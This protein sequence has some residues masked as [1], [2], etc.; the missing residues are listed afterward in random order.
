MRLEAFT[1]PGDS[2]PEFWTFRS[3]DGRAQRGLPQKDRISSER[4]DLR[5]GVVNG[6]MIFK[7]L[8]IP[9]NRPASRREKSIKEST[10]LDKRSIFLAARLSFSRCFISFTSRKRSRIGALMSVNGV[11]DVK[12]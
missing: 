1:S 7:E 3:L 4:T 12:E 8:R 10:S 11:L 5:K 6:D 2:K 9:S